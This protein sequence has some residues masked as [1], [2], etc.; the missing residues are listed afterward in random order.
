[1]PNSP[2]IYDS[3]P[4]DGQ[5]SNR[6]KDQPLAQRPRER[7][8]QHGAAALSPAELIAILLRTGVRKASAVDLGRQLL[9]KY[10]SL[11]AVAQASVDDLSS[12]RG[13]GPAKAVTLVAAFALA[14]HLA[15][16]LQHESPVLE[17]P[18]TVV[19]ML[20][21]QSRLLDVET[22]Q[23]LLLNTRHRLI[24]I[25]QICQGTLDTII[26]HPREVFKPALTASAA[27]II[28]VHNH[29]SGDPTPSRADIAVT[30][31]LASAGKVLKI[32]LLD[33]IILGRAT[34]ERSKPYCSLRES[35]DFDAA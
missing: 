13:I 7:L 8:L 31:E 16:E 21:A 12:I 33:H 4:A 24:R 18:D 34:P 22:L 1:M 2:N 17:S 30:R 32:E 19:Q 28:L 23:V 14:A 26:I 3:A 35:G 10:G 25:E 9:Q 15:R 20:G 6:L 11:G 5:Y 29:P 27:A